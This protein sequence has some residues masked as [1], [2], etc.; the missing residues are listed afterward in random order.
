[1]VDKRALKDKAVEIGKSVSGTLQSGLESGNTQSTGNDGRTITVSQISEGSN[2]GK[3]RVAG[4]TAGYGVYDT[5]KAAI[6]KA[7]QVYQSKDL[8]SGIAVKNQ[9]GAVTNQSMGRVEGENYGAKDSQGEK[10]SSKSP[11]KKESSTG[12]SH[13]LFGGSEREQSADRPELPFMGGFG[14]N[15]ESQEREQPAD[16]P[17]L[18]FMGG[19]GPD[20]GGQER[21][22]PG[23]PIG[24]PMFGYGEKSKK[25]QDEN[26]E[27]GFRWM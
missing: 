14:P 11:S 6:T 22:R 5:K 16:R 8:Y 15:Q 27:S 10:T 20:Q 23:P 1:M 9:R 7:K 26:T 18:S 4:P 21:D 19:F 13:P 17:E 3:W 2:E 24:G 12:V 25:D